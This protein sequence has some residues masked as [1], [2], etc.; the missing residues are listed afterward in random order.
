MACPGRAE[1][2]WPTTLTVSRN[3]DRAEGSSVWEPG[4]SSARAWDG[5]GVKPVT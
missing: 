4:R 3:E 1:G 2:R 5:A